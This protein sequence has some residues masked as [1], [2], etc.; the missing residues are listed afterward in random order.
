MPSHREEGVS[1]STLTGD[2]NQLIQVQRGVTDVT[3][4][5]AFSLVT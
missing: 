2:A 5:A 3:G 4:E 1:I